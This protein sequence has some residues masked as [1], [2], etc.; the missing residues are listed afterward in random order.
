MQALKQLTDISNLNNNKSQCDSSQV[1]LFLKTCKN[2]SDDE[3]FLK[4]TLML[5]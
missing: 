1:N 3:I 5:F 4:V 2:Y